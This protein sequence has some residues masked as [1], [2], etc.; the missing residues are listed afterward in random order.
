MVILAYVRFCRTIANNIAKGERMTIG[1][2]IR[3]RRKEL[4][5][6]VDELAQR[7]G[8]DRSTV[9]RYESGDI[10]NFP[11]DLLLPITEALETTPQKLLS[12]IVTSNEWLSERAR[13]W[14]NA[15]GGYEFAD[16]EIEVFYE[17]AKYFMKIRDGENYDDKI[18]S[19]FVLFKQL[20]E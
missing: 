19:L 11:I 2:Q 9:Y 4:N 10:E 7:I 18:K 12:T 8:K 15:T 6:S 13:V 3:K 16:A 17:V 1:I 14:F 5:M 20:N